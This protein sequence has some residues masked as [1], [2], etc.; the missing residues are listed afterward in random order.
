MVNM[1]CKNCNTE[2]SQNYC[3]NCGAPAKLKR[4]D[5]HYIQHEIEHLLHFE[6][7][8]LYTIKELTTR[9]GQS[10]RAFISDNRTKLVKPIVFIIVSSLIYTIIVHS[11]HI[12]DGYVKYGNTETNST[13]LIFKWIQ[14][15]YGYSNII[16]GFFIALWIKVFFRKYQYNFFEILILLCYVMGVGMLIF[17]LF[18][19]VEGI[20]NIQLMQI[21]GIIS[22]IYSAWAIGQFF[23]KNK[24]INYLKSFFAYLLGFMTFSFAALI[25]GA[26]IDMIIKH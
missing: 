20:S 16:M 6:K 9:P 3:P 23:D 19:T 2:L 13:I 24:W 18:A 17:A 5:R 12:E 25:L 15:H 4:I 8:F 21:S 1:N 7:G 26:A 11:F 10:I 22:F 14:E